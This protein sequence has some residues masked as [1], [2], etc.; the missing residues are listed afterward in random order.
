MTR[1][2]HGTCFSHKPYRNGT[3]STAMGTPEKTG[4]QLLVATKE[5]PSP[6][7]RVP[8]PESRAPPYQPLSPRSGLTLVSP[9]GHI[10]CKGHNMRNRLSRRT[11]LGK[12]GS[13]AVGVGEV[14]ML[15]GASLQP[16]SSQTAKPFENEPCDSIGSK[17]KQIIVKQL[18]VDEAKVTP[19]ARFVEDL[20]ADSLDVVELIMAFE[21]AFSIEI[22]DKDAE[23]IKTVREAVDYI[24]AHQPKSSS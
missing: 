6:E 22:P 23:N 16:A 14:A 7:P 13:A 11:F 12:L 9:S 15:G 8:C 18:G 20:G 5:L 2:D 1:P 3:P 10:S 19:N 21:E 4:L 17:V 24:C